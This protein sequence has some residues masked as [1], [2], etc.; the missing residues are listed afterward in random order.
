[1][2][3]RTKL[4]IRQVGH[5]QKRYLGMAVC[6]LLRR[7]AV[8]LA[9]MLCAMVPGLA[10][11]QGILNLGDA[12]VTGFSG[13]RQPDILDT[14][15]DETLIDPDGIS[16]RINSLAAP[17]YVWDG[18]V[19]PAETARSFAARDVGQV[20]GVALDDAARPNIYFTATSA[21][22]L[23]ITAADSD[24]DGRAER[25]KQGRGDAQWM[26]GMWGTADAAALN[27]ATV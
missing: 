15:S 16:A 11:E 22:G 17:A 19:W 20:F 9:L 8:A 14:A 6:R 7:P 1:M 25:L 12:V 4:I 2:V 26:A 3:C 21:Y 27:R 18:R 10:Q 24:N 23:H 5:V 13:V